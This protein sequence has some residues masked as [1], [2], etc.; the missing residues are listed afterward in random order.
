MLA[1]QYLRI[2][3]RSQPLWLA[4]F[5]VLYP[6]LFGIL[7]DFVGLPSAIKYLMDVCWL[8]LVALIGINLNRKRVV[9]EKS[10]T[11]YYVWIL[12]FFVVTLVVYLFNFQSPIY[13]LWGFRNNFR[14]YIAF[15]AFI[16][17]FCVDDITDLLKKLD[18]LFWINSILCI[19]QYFIL[20]VKQ[21]YLGGLFGTEKGCNGYLNIFLTIIVIKSIIYYLNKAE[22]IGKVLAK[23]GVSLIVASLAELKFFYV[24]FMV[25]IIASVFI[26]E[27]S[28][29]K[30]WLVIGGI[31]G[32]FLSVN[33]LLII[34]PYYLDFFSIDAMLESA[35]VGGYSRADELNRLTT[36][37]Q[38]TQNFLTTVPER[39]FGLGLGN[40]DTSAY[41]FLKTP[42]YMQ[43]SYIR[44][45]WFS[46][47]YLL[48]ETGFIGLAFFMG[49]FVL[50]FVYSIKCKNNISNNL[51]EKMLCQIAALT[52]LCA[53]MI[54][55]YNSS[56]RT[57]AGY[58]IYFVM[59][60]PFV[61]KKEGVR[62]DG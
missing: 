1:L 18:I 13:Y 3:K 60:F 44:Y 31:I 25:V 16:L 20:G 41:D 37:P 40:C 59:S 6:F 38:I 46:T 5:I 62:L 4:E 19:F 55:V 36:V 22:N 28:W 14:F 61:V 54:T 51:Q 43:Y 7:I 53:V 35:T 34:F 2:K 8:L 45:H 39:L 56:L 10:S 58:L 21:D 30:L 23:C 27:F 26:T 50:I 12:L 24:E 57:E 33:L 29:R 11:L 17:F 52:A 49:F 48:L 15:F 47:A 32:V 9:V 42:F